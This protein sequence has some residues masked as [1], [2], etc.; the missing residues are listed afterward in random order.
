[1]VPSQKC[2]VPLSKGI[3]QNDNQRKGVG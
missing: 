3:L 2:T 1:V